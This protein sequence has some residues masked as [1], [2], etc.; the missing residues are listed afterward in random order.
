M[1]LHVSIGGS[2]NLSKQFFNYYCGLLSVARLKTYS[3]KPSRE[4]RA[5]RTELKEQILSQV[6][7]GRGQW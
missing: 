3:Q 5:W 7:Q 1:N 2:E 6:F 4:K